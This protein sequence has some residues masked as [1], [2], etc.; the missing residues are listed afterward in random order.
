MIFHDYIILI[1]EHISSGDMCLSFGVSVSRSIVIEIFCGD[2]FYAF[3]IL[4]AILLPVKSPVASTVFWIAVFEAVL[5]ASVA[6]Y[7]T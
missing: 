2:F 6:D 1:L 3:I 5:S 7:L 4:L